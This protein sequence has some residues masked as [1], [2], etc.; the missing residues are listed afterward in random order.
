[1]PPAQKTILFVDDEPL[2]LASLRR[3]LRPMRSEWR[4]LFASSGQEA[5]DRLDF[6][7]VDVLVTDIRMPGIDGY[8]LLSHVQAHHPNV[9][10]LVLS[11]QTE[12]EKALRTLPCAHYFL[13][14][15]CD[16]QRIREVVRRSLALRDLLADPSLTRFVES[17]SPLPPVPPL[18]QQLLE[19]LAGARISVRDLAS[20]VESDPVICQRVLHLIN[21]A[22]SSEQR[23]VQN[24]EQAAQY[25]GGNLIKNLT[26][27]FELEKWLE[28]HLVPKNFSVEKL[29]L[30]SLLSAR[31]AGRLLDQPH[32][33]E[34]AFTAAMLLEVGQLLLAVTSREKYREIFAQSLDHARPL[35][36]VEAEQFGFT[37][38]E[39]GACLLGQWGVPYSVVE[40]VA[41]HH[42]P[43][44]VTPD[45]FDIVGA[46]HISQW[47]AKL[48]LADEPPPSPPS[49]PLDEEYL[50][51]LRIGD[52]VGVWQSTLK[53]E[54][55]V[56][57]ARP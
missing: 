5:V 17:L 1:M 44:R 34:E 20:V 47:L 41:F 29:R 45:R 48:W 25:L 14:K 24:L 8:A 42:A 11:G 16:P 13:S 53:Q 57:G 54:L 23:Q 32:D 40:A 33:R 46:V 56:E 28:Q 52:Q 15:P 39:V 2:I 26:L 50:E 37:H 27:T 7:T 19:K 38:A 18:Y 21:S 22:L 35:H 30:E 43:S 4:F 9:V 36:E 10:R 55:A 6:E 31:V 51:L 12:L 3:L 49:G